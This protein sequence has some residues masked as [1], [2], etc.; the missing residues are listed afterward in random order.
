MF[1]VHVL[2]YGHTFPMAYC[3]L[4]NKQR[5][6]Y[7]RAFLHLKDKA[8]AMGLS[9]D[10]LVVVS[11]FELAMVQAAAMSFSNSHHRGCYYHFMQAIWRK[12]WSQP[13]Y[14]AIRFSDN[15]YVAI[16]FSDN[17]LTLLIF[18]HSGSS[19][20]VGRRVSQPQWR[21]EGICAEDGISGIFPTDVRQTSMA[22]DTTGSPKHPASR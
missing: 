13:Y 5:Q 14:V 19:S 9:L 1:T 20:W 8:V 4:P 16:R 12:V 17:R 21:T 7:N 2:L 18:I 6:S 10:P 22:C 11:D 15:T 3:L